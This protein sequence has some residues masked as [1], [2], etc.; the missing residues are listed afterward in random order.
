MFLSRLVH[1]RDSAHTAEILYARIVARA[2]EPA[3]YR[4]HGVP[5]TVEGRFEMIALH[6]FLVLHRLKESKAADGPDEGALGQALFDLMFADMDRSLREMGVG[7]LGVGRRVKAM[8]QAFYGRIAAYEGG[9]A[10]GD[11]A[12][13]VALERNVFAGAPPPGGGPV[14][15]RYVCAC[16]RGLAAIPGD[17]LGRGD[18]DFPPVPSPEARQ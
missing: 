4:D 17:A 1:R 6:A 11:G 8:A 10:G 5:D 13:A 14:L 15:A 3:F 9:L 18:I 12:L 2:R 16:T 7:D